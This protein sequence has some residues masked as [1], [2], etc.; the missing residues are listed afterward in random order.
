[1]KRL[2][3]IVGLPI[4]LA[5]CGASGGLYGTAPA[6]SPAATVAPI[7]TPTLGAG[8]SGYGY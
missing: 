3:W 8:S 5:A 1:M 2:L 7:P 4:F 6:T